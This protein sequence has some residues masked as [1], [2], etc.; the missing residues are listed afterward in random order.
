MGKA[1]SYI[2]PGILCAGVRSLLPL[3]LGEHL[4]SVPWWSHTLVVFNAFPRALPLRRGKEP[5][6]GRE[7]EDAEE[8]GAEGMA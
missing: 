2:Y 6:H 5:G 4:F 3:E 8:V 7:R 1:A